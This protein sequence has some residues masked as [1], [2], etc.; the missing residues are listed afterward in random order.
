MSKIS[1]NQSKCWKMSSWSYPQDPTH[2]KNHGIYLKN[3]TGGLVPSRY[4]CHAQF[5]IQLNLNWAEFSFILTFSIIYVAA[6]LKKYQKS[7]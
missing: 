7:L 4:Y 6:A 5:K 3:R 1:Q 2:A